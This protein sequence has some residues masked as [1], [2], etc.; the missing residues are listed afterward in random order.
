M[1]AR[2][3]LL[4]IAL[5]LIPLAAFAAPPKSPRDDGSGPHLPFGL[6]SFGAALVDQSIYICGGHLGSAH[7]YAVGEESDQFL[8]LDLRLP[9]RWE[10]VGKTPPRAGL[11]VVSYGGKVYRI[12]GFEARNKKGAKEDL[13]STND[14]SAF[15]PA[16]GHWT[17]LTPMPTPRS[18]HAAAVIGSRV[19]VVG[20]WE[21]RGNQPSVWHDTAL[22]ID[23][24]SERPQW[25]EIPK[26]PFRRRALAL[27]ECQGKLYA[28]GGMEEAGATTTSVFVL[29]VATGK[30]TPGPSLPGEGLQGFGGAA[31]TC[32]G[33]LYATT[34]SG[35]VS[36]LSADGTRWEEAA[37]LRRPRFFHQLLCSHDSSLIAL[38]G[39][40]MEEGKN[41]SVEIIPLNEVRETQ[42]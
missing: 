6:T 14:L 7:E 24:A 9:K 12:G 33:R 4:S 29:D 39:A 18:S 26:P 27:G 32:A 28:L 17:D 16:T 35:R 42:R 34:Y 36:R 22:Q 38:G 25:R 13:H 37:H 8:R 1:L 23:L 30:W 21:L 41:L 15:D 3:I 5:T 19:Y 20:G 2:L 31:A 40:N 11:A 10:V